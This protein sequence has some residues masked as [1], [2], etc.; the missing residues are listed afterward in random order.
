MTEILVIVA[1][2]AA[3]F[4]LPRMTGR[5]PEKGSPASSFS[6]IGG[7]VRLAIMGSVVWPAGAA[8]FLK[9]W[10]GDWSLFLY[11]GMGPVIIF[12]GIYW[13]LSGFKK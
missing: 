13:V 5:R 8:F 4:M 12:W 9:P 6:R 11:A 7:W 2:A 10:N 3:I 1:I